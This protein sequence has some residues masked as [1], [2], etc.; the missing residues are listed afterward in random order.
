MEL[1]QRSREFFQ[2]SRCNDYIFY[3]DC[4]TLLRSDYHERRSIPAETKVSAVKV[5]SDSLVVLKYDNEMEFEEIQ[6][7]S[8][9]KRT[10]IKSAELELL[11][12]DAKNA[13]KNCVLDFEYNEG[14]LVCIFKEN[15]RRFTASINLVTSEMNVIA[16]WSF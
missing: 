13:Y 2:L 6:A 9:Q 12:K 15:E 3:N 4:G 8:L 14:K 16:E 1:I 11:F 10:L 5:L 7:D